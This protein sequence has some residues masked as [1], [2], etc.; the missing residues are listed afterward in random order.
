MS[1][2]GLDKNSVIGLV[3]I[4]A[5][6]LIFSYITR[7]TEEEVK[8]KELAKQTEQVEQEKA[9]EDKTLPFQQPEEIVSIDSLTPTKDS[10]QDIA[11]FTQYGPFANSLKGEDQH[12]TLENEK[13][14]VT[15][16]NKGGR[17]SSVELKDFH[18]YDSLPLM[19]FNEDSSRFNLELTIP[20]ITGGNSIRQINTED[21]YFETSETAFT[22]SGTDEK[23]ISFKL[24]GNSK[25]EYIEYVYTLKG[26]SYV[27]D[28]DV[29]TVGLDKVLSPHSNLFMNWNMFTPNQEKTIKNQQHISTIYYQYNNSEMDY[30]NPMKYEEQTLDASIDWIMFKQQYFN[31]TIIATKTPF[32]KTDA[33]I[34]TIELPEGQTKNYV[35]G[36]GTDLT[37]PYNGGSTESFAMQFYFGPN[38]YETLK[39]VGYGIENSIDFGWPVIKQVNKYI[40]RNVFLFFNSF[41]M[42][43]GLVILL[44]T[45]TI[46]LLLF[47][48]T[49]KTYLSS[50]K[51]RVLKPEIDALKEKITDKM[52]LQQAT[53]SL[54]RQTGVNPLAGCI[55]MLIQMPILFALFRFFP[56]TFD[57]RQK[58]F[59]WAEDLS[60]YDSIYELPFHIPMYGDHVSLFTLLMA[61]SM[62]FYTKAN[63]QMTAGAMEGPMAGQMKIM[64]YLMPIM[65]LFFFNSY[66]AGLSFYY[67]VANVITILQQWVIRKWIVDEEKILAK[68]QL[69]KIKPKKKSGFAAKLE[70]KMKEAQQLQDKRKKK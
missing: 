12:F 60:T 57:M 36:M 50:A 59:L 42:Q 70:A 39:N 14:I 29:N 56:A 9:T 4:S 69:N 52:K 37:I 44:L 35:Q 23:S 1:K 62:I 63:S 34:K 65:M 19:L 48:I 21:L 64:T 27:V 13:I 28:F 41:G 25:N 26:N 47:P 38:K 67:L 43:I 31:T 10:L 45:F 54:Y 55:P 20:G 33:K 11:L 68:I 5:I 2:K 49:W 40:I 66:A 15:I 18:T 3:L 53:M 30:I 24:Y 22:I 61:I 58:S 6:L 46:K 32:L 17:V 16:A 51:M 8:A 7:P